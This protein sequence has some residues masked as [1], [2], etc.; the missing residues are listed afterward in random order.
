VM[1]GRKEGE[2]GRSERKEE[3]EKGL[4]DEKTMNECERGRGGREEP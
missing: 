2:E 1:N 3:K 4:V